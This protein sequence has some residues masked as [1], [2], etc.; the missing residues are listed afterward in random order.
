MWSPRRK[1]LKRL[2]QPK[3]FADFSSPVVSCRAC[4]GPHKRNP[5][6]LALALGTCL[7]SVELIKAI[8]ECCNAAWRIRK[9][10]L[11]QG[12]FGNFCSSLSVFVHAQEEPSAL[13]QAFGAALVLLEWNKAN[14]G[15]GHATGR[16]RKEDLSA[17][18]FGCFSSP[19]LVFAHAHHA[20]GAQRHVCPSC[21]GSILLIVAFIP[22][23]L[24]R[25][26][27]SFSGRSCD[28]NAPHWW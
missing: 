22:V 16:I 13:M 19:L 11:S 27:R 14:S 12:F 9:E 26:V 1:D 24:T 25:M 6:P 20:G 18:C 10:N 21:N 23:L 15:C 2:P 17:G 5:G 4:P 8:S 7:A 28:W 3:S